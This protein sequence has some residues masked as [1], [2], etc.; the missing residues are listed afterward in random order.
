MEPSGVKRKRSESAIPS[1]SLTLS[2]LPQGSINPLSH[3]PTTLSQFLVAGLADSER[4]PTEVLKNFPHSPWQDEQTVRKRRERR[5][6]S[7]ASGFESEGYTSGGFTSTDAETDFEANGDGTASNLP[8][9]KKYAAERAALRPLAQS[10]AIFLS[11][12]DIPSAK[13]AF[14]LLMRSK[15]SGKQVDIRR[16]HYW[17]LGAEILMREQPP[18]EQAWGPRSPSAEEQDKRRVVYPLVNVPKV[19]QYFDDLIR[20]FPYHKA[21]KAAASAMQ[22]HPALLSYEMYQVHAHYVQALKQAEIDAENWREDLDDPDHDIGSHV[23]EEELGGGLV[24]DY[25]DPSQRRRSFGSPSA[26]QE[27]Q[28]LQAKNN[29]RAQTLASLR[30]M[31]ERMDRLLEDPAFSRSGELLRL[32]GVLAL[33]ISDLTTPFGQL[34]LQETRDATVRKDKEREKARKL[35]VRAIERG[36]S[37]DDPVRRALGL[38][39][40]KTSSQTT[41]S[42]LP[43]RGSQG[44]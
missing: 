9:D 44:S 6:S 23:P 35:F 41:Y 27:A 8:R 25:P 43:Y 29:I 15:V 3:A 28:L 18:Q 30:E 42:S 37:V 32:I 16:N 14:G 31:M 10:I 2:Q 4:V 38:E 22:F 21:A 19:K 17:E 12:D 33:Y 7:I 26:A 24:D 5:R 34:S 20:N 13:R 36:A 1:S 11:K 39:V 40:K